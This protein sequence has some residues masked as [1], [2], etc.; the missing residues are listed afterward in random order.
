MEMKDLCAC[1]TTIGKAVH[2]TSDKVDMQVQRRQ[3]PA[4]G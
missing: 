1:T 4:I 3:L 2:H